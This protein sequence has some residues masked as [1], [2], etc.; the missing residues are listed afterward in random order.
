[1]KKPS[2]LK[3]QKL[4]GVAQGKRRYDLPLNQSPGLGALRLLVCAMTVLCVLGGGL[5]FS[6]SSFT[7]NWRSVAQ[8]SL[9]IEI[10]AIDENGTIRNKS[11]MQDIAKIIQSELSNIPAIDRIEIMD[12]ADVLSL[13]EPW[14]GQ[15]NGLES[16]PVPGLIAVTLGD[17]DDISK[18]KIE[19]TLFS[20]DPNIQIDANERWLSD[21]LSL[22]QSIQLF[23]VLVMIL[24][25]GITGL[26]I[27]S[28]VKSRMAVYAEEI[29]L[30]HLM[31]AEDDYIIRQFQRHTFLLAI[32]A[33][34]GGLILGVLLLI[35]FQ[36]ATGSA[37]S[38]PIQ[39]SFTDFFGLILIPLLMAG[40]GVLTA[41][42]SVLHT[43]RNM[44]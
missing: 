10:P 16:I 3:R 38:I 22:S 21:I 28:G 24:L 20:I 39:T 11:D 44:P 4:L 36:G 31:G 25:F 5:F 42:Y 18:Q 23:T 12:R 41:R 8:Q 1:M 14:L 27:A 40:L 19:R 9:T 7:Q 17:Q 13:M 37:L 43:L 35:L 33:S 2:F 34:I 29:E 6:L 32:I 26:S 30:L 15:S